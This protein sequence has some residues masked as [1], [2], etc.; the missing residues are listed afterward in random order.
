MPKYVPKPCF[1]CGADVVDDNSETCS[2]MCAQQKI[3]FE[4][5]Y[6]ALTWKDYEGEEDDWS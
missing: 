2:D 3:M 5:N 1:I 4:E 6:P